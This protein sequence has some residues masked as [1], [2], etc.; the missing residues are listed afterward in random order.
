MPPLLRNILAVVAGLVVGGAV[1]MALVTI[2]PS[3]IPP[4]DGID[5]TTSEGLK[6]WAHLLEPRHY[7]MPFL[8]HA[9]GTAVGAM[10]AWLIASSHK[11]RFA[12]VIGIAFLAGGFAAVNMIPAPNWFI[13]L[14]LI[15][16]YLPMAWL[17]TRIAPRLTGTAT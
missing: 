3:L 11:D 9:S 14:D 13:A 10:V 8:A 4:P 12:W 1:N 5:V 7:I 16:A 17:A 2:G 6:A 15:V